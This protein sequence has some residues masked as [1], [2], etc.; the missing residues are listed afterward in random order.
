MICCLDLEGILVPEI[1]IEV[2]K[3]T[4]IRELR[5]TTRDVPDYDALMRRRLA[6]LRGHRIRLEDIQRVVAGI[7]PLPGA[8]AFLDKLRAKRQ[9]I[10]LSDTYYEFAY[11]LMRKL[12][13]PTLLCNRLEIDKKGFI[14][15]YRLRQKEGKKQAVLAFKRLGFRVSAV[16]DSYNDISMLKAAH[17]AVLFNAPTN[18][19]R[20]F[21]KFRT[22][23]NYKELLRILTA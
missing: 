14:A 10:L 22:A 7:R 19:T 11:P 3:D 20:E 12:G 6:I 17:W 4:G 1:W 13:Y 8:T 16:G 21:P 18:I 15:G 9:A 2:A 23:G 5:L